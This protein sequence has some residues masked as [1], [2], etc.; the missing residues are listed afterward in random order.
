MKIPPLNF[1]PRL[2]SEVVI[3]GAAEQT[4]KKYYTAH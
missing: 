3:E 1:P 2:H 4:K